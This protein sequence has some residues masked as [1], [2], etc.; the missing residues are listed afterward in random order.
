M[1]LFIAILWY[2]LTLFGNSNTVVDKSVE[3]LM[4]KNLKATESVQPSQK[5]TTQTGLQTVEPGKVEMWEPEFEAEEP[6]I[7]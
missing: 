6:I 5:F 7:E 1:Q 3:P 2:L 4:E